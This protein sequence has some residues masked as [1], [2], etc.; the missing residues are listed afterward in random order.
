[1][2][3]R[4]FPTGNHGACP[5]VTA[6]LLAWSLGGSDLPGGVWICSGIPSLDFTPLTERESGDLGF[7][8]AFSF[9]VAVPPE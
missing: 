5:C 9:E 2:K 3:P 7:S 8:R 1:M 6:G 4:P